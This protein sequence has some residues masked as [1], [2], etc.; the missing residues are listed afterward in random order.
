MT[1]FEWLKPYTHFRIVEDGDHLLEIRYKGTVVERYA[2]CGVTEETLR[3][4]V[5]ELND[6]VGMLERTI[7]NQN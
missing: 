5:E 7:N 6:N 4:R 2:Q 1:N 3:K